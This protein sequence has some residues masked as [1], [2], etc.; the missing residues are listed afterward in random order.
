MF[1]STFILLVES[2]E[3]NIYL[4]AS[5]LLYLL[6]I[7]YI[8]PYNAALDYPQV[9]LLTYLSLALFTVFIIKEI[10]LNKEILIYDS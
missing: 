3:K 6:S 10:K 5:L 9:N 4:I 8:E 7:G 2:F 1:I